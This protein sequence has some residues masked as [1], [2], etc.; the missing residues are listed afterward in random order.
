MKIYRVARWVILAI[1]AIVLVLMFHHPQPLVAGKIDRQVAA[2]NAE[3]FQTK[4]G[5]LQQ[6]HDR[7]ESGTE[8]RLGSEEIGAALLLSDAPAFSAGQSEASGSTNPQIPVKAQQV[9]FDQDQVKAQFTTQLAG[10]DVIV[11]LSGHVGSKEGY[12]EFIPTSFQ[13]GSLPVPLSLVQEQLNKKLLDPA[14]REKL[15]LPDF[16]SDLRIENGQ[17]VIVER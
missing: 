1:A 9:V 4:M 13:I 17:L 11:S 16:V 5:Q 2:A 3:S 7:G 6:A 8:T 14:N 10:Q 15:K 12:V